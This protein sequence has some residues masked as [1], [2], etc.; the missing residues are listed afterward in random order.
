VAHLDEKMK[1]L[2]REEKLK[3][4]TLY[5]E[6][7]ELLGNGTM[8]LAGHDPTKVSLTDKEVLENIKTAKEG[9]DLN[10][11][12]VV[13]LALDAQIHLIRELSQIL[14]LTAEDLGISTGVYEELKERD[15]FVETQKYMATAVYSFT[16]SAPGES[17]TA[18]SAD[19]G[20]GSSIAELDEAMK[21]DSVLEKFNT[22]DPTT[23]AV[24]TISDGAGNVEVVTEPAA[25]TKTMGEVTMKFSCDVIRTVGKF[26]C[27]IL[28]EDL[29][30]MEDDISNCIEVLGDLD[31]SDH[32]RAG[33][34]DALK[35][36]L[37]TGDKIESGSMINLNK[38]L[39]EIARR[40]PD[41]LEA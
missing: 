3:I 11:D 15:T 32:R 30:D 21:F 9:G 5:Q 26:A 14:N 41:L 37:N 39:P 29:G 1:T 12:K 27:M 4:A 40:D 38:F 36:N 6:T 31:F 18:D 17:V 33:L 13:S 10:V 2:S 20:S 22:D 28:P 25:V 34:W 7:K 35:S 24:T 8:Q 16:T 19:E 23:E